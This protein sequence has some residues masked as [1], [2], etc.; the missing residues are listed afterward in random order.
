MFLHAVLVRLFLLLDRAFCHGRR[1]NRGIG[2][3]DHCR[4]K[5]REQD[6]EEQ[7]F[8]AGKTDASVSTCQR[9]FDPDM[10]CCTN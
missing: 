6:E 7:A 2:I 4:E 3:R 5:K 8:H 10:N 9:Q 1:E